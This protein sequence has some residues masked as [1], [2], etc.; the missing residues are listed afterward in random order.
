MLSACP[1]GIDIYFDNVGGQLLEAVLN[2]INTNARIAFCG[3]VS[4]YTRT[5]SFG[6]SNLFQLVTNCANIQGFLTHT[7][8]DRYD[9]ARAR[10]SHWL[11]DGRLV[12]YEQMYEGVECCGQAFSDL[13]AGKNY[14]KTVVKV[15]E[16]P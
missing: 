9:E 7:K 16:D 4:D 6:P 10:L 12:S 8:V 5:E 14:G 15:A 2:Q 11:S 3:A 1:N 13:F